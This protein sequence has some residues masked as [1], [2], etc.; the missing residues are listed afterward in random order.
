MATW[1]EFSGANKCLDYLVVVCV[2]G[3]NQ[4]GLVGPVFGLFGF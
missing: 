3:M 2:S 4:R 1:W